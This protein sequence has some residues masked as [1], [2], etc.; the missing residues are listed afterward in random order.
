MSILEQLAVET[1]P[2]AAMAFARK[3]QRNRN[4]VR[5]FIGIAR[6]C[7]EHFCGKTMRK[8]DFNRIYSNRLY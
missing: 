4:S 1:S 5:T 6:L 3:S 8:W 7:Q 2:R